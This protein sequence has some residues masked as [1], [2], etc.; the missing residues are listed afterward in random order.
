[1][2]ERSTRGRADP[3]TALPLVAD[4]AQARGRSADRPAR[5]GGS[6]GPRPGR[7]PDRRSRQQIPVPGPAWFAQEA[8]ND[9]LP[10]PAS[11]PTTTM[12]DLRVAASRRVTSRGRGTV[13][14]SATGMSRSEERTI[15]GFDR[16]S[17]T[18]QHPSRLDLSVI[19]QA[20]SGVSCHHPATDLTRVR[21]TANRVS[22]RPCRRSGPVSRLG[23]AGADGEDLGAGMRSELAIQ[24]QGE[25][26]HRVVRH[27]A[28]R[29]R[30]R[31]GSG[32]RAAGAGSP[33]RAGSTSPRPVP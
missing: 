7:G 14:W 8:T 5:R 1:M 18:R 20:L 26:L 32:S 11:D 19:I 16:T 28:G 3:C 9:V 2:I 31:A 24:R 29:P 12:R 6:R 13:S 30:S 17:G 21:S 23:Q 27:V 25:C 10:D 15:P 33:A 22:V 4:H